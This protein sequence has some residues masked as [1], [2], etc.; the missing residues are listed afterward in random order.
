MRARGL[1]RD[2]GAAAEVVGYALTFFLGSALLTLSLQAFLLSRDLTEELRATNELRVV[3]NRVAAEVLQAGFVASH[4]AEARYEAVVPLPELGGRAYYVNAS[5]GE[6]WANTTDG[7]ISV[8]STAFQVEE[9]PDLQ[10]HGTAFSSQGYVRV[11]YE[12][13]ADGRRTISL[14]I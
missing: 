1:W 10:L 6:V 7:K 2:E 13:F 3:S 4:L 5:N 11:T 9:L 14:G 12:R 8:S